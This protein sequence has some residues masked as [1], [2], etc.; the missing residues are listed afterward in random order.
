METG[1]NT[2]ED[3]TRGGCLINGRP[4]ALFFE[5]L[6][7]LQLFSFSYAESVPKNDVSPTTLMVKDRDR[8]RE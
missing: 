8:E 4:A 3:W 2:P 1:E 6:F 7:S 5:Y